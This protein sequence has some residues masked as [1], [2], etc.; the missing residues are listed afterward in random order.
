L[1]ICARHKNGEVN[2]ATKKSG[3][4]ITIRHTEGG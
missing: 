2:Y 4:Q 1:R 3:S